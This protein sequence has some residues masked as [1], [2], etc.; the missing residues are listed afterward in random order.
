MT[1]ADLIICNRYT[2]ENFLP[3]LQSQAVRFYQGNCS[4]C[5]HRVYY[6]DASRDLL[7]KHPEMPLVCIECAV[8][9]LKANPN[10]VFATTPKHLIEL[11]RLQNARKRGLN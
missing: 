2:A 7:T 3:N 6:S 11:A 4:R 9:G 5:S 8:S 1:K 10:V